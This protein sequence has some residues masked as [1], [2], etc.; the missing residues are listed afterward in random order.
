MTRDVTKICLFHSTTFI[1]SK[2]GGEREKRE[3]ERD[4]ELLRQFFER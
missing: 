4:L 2:L 1:E 3:R